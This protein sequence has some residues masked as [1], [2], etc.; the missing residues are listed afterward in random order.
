MTITHNNTLDFP[1]A[2]G[3][4]RIRFN[5]TRTKVIF[6]LHEK[7]GKLRNVGGELIDVSVSHRDDKSVVDFFRHV[8]QNIT[9][10]TLTRDKCVLTFKSY[11]LKY[12]IHDL[13][14]TLFNQ[15][16]Y[17]WHNAKYAKRLNRLYYLYFVDV[18]IR[19]QG[20]D[21]RLQVLQDFH[22]LILQPL[23]KGR[24]AGF[25]EFSDMYCGFGLYMCEF[26]TL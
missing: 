11:T 2:K 6:T 1:G 8:R 24:E 18:F 17:P 15:S 23:L 7:S 22:D 25:D 9:E 4:V 10:Y 19:V 20:S 26:L 21:D 14:N 16:L 3:D 5:L 12:L 13:E